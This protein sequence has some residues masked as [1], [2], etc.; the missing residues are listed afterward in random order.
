MLVEGESCTHQLVEGLWLQLVEGSLTIGE[1]I[2]QSG[3]AISTEDLG[4][5]EIIAKYSCRGTLI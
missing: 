5:V 4:L 3:D 2:L 1:H